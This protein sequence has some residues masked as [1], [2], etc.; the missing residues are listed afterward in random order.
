MHV[1]PDAGA[2][3]CVY[4]PASKLEKVKG[5]PWTMLSVAMILPSRLKVTEKGVVSVESPLIVTVTVIALV[6]T[7]GGRAA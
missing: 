7:F 2:S 3:V 5:E 4:V 6:P 1:Y